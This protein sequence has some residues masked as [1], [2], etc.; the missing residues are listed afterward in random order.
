MIVKIN[1]NGYLESP[2]ILDA[3]T[4]V[5]VSDS[6]YG[7]LTSCPIAKAWKWNFTTR[8]FEQV[9]QKNLSALRTLRE[10]ECFP[11][12]N[13]GQGWYRTLTQSQLEE[14]DDW[15]QAWL[16]VTETKIIPEKPEWLD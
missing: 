11:V 3:T 5:K 1:Q 7:E 2:Y 4:P 6:I 9:P 14:L 8:Q 13:R 12:I 16:D 15:Y 10:I